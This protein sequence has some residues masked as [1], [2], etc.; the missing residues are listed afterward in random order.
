MLQRFRWKGETPF[1]HQFTLTLR[2]NDEFLQCEENKVLDTSERSPLLRKGRKLFDKVV[3]RRG[4]NLNTFAEWSECGITR[5]TLRTTAEN[6]HPTLIID[7]DPSTIHYHTVS[8]FQ[9]QFNLLTLPLFK[10]S[11]TEHVSWLGSYRYVSLVDITQS[12]YVRKTINEERPET[13]KDWEN[14]FTLLARLQEFPHIVNLAGVTTSRNPYSPTGEDVVTAFLLEY[15]KG[16]TLRDVIGKVNKVRLRGW[17]LEVIKGLQEMHCRGI[18]HGDIKPDNV[19]ITE[20][21]HTKIIDLAQSGYTKSC[22]APEFP[23]LFESRDQWR[24]S[25]DIYSYGVVYW[26]LLSGDTAGLPELASD[27]L[28]PVTRFIAKCVAIDPLHRPSTEDIIEVL[29]HLSV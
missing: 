1:T 22:H 7:E 19:I 4:C 20:S 10:D 17:M 5:F 23:E 12:R 16:G 9:R 29:E 8:E 15:G 11:D 6:T 25:V 27:D 3:T 2:R 14:E 26:V 21:G 28:S 18:I 24:S 13:L